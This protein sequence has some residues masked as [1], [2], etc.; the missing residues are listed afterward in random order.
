MAGRVGKG[1]LSEVTW[2]QAETQLKV[3]PDLKYPD[4]YRVRRTV[5]EQHV[6]VD[7]PSSSSVTF[8]RQAVLVPGPIV[9]AGP[10]GYESHCRRCM[11]H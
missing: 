3:V 6:T 4:A 7:E 1:P 8:A 2:S 10:D 11:M 9:P 5:G